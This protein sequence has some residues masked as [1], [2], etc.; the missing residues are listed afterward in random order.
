MPLEKGE[1]EVV[2]NCEVEKG[3]VG[4]KWCIFFFL[5]LLFELFLIVIVLAVG[6]NFEC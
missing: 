4:V 2:G 3:E 6:W 1:E 5:L